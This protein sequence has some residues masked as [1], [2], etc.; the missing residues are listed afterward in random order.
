MIPGTQFTLNEVAPDK[1]EKQVAQTLTNKD[2][3]IIFTVTK[4]GTYKVTETKA[5]KGYV[6]GSTPYTAE[7]TVD[8]TKAFQKQTLDLSASADTETAVK[9]DLTVTGDAYAGS[10]ISNIRDTGT[11]TLTKENADRQSLNGVKFELYKKQKA[12]NLF[13]ALKELFTGK[14]YKYKEIASET[15]DEQADS[16]GTLT[17]GDLPWG[18][19]YIVETGQKGGYAL[20]GTKYE[21]TIDK[22]SG[23]D[24]QLLVSLG[25]IVNAY[26][27]VDIKKTDLNGVALYGGV[28]KL[29]G[30]F[31]DGSTE[32]Q[33]TTASEAETI[34]NKLITG[35]E[36]TLSEVSA[37]AGHIRTKETAAIRL[38]E[39]GTLISVK[40]GLMKSDS[41][42]II[43][44]NKPVTMTVQKYSPLGDRLK[45][46]VFA[47]TG[48]FAPDYSGKARMMSLSIQA[49]ADDS[50]ETLIVDDDHLDIL[51]G[52]LIVGNIY[53]L[54]E[55]TPPNGYVVGGKVEFK[56]LENGDIEMLSE[57]TEYT[58]DKNTGRIVMVDDATT[59]RL[60]KTDEAGNYLGGAVY[61]VEGK[62]ADGTDKKEFSP[63]ANG[64]LE[65]H[66]LFIEGEQY[67]LTE[68]KA[69]K[70][71]EA[72]NEPVIF[73]FL[74][75]NGAEIVSAPEGMA[76]LTSET[77]QETIE[78][79]TYTINIK[80]KKTVEQT[81][82]SGNNTDK[83]IPTAAGR[84]EAA[85]TGDTADIINW[86]ILGTVAGA[87]MV[88]ALVL[89][90]R[91]KG[92]Q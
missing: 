2:G 44:Q 47:V 11:V 58:L 12:G 76:S 50:V 67:T 40:G 37:P 3:E 35:E 54:Q 71:Y 59:L 31:L 72:L 8:N 56:V 68:T 57:S 81:Q 15:W 88:L 5:A 86:A 46:C 74:E 21:F 24:I 32:Y 34:V 77:K 65:I 25:K 39:D 63:T 73:N 33:W 53:T 29:E 18:S 13:E 55:Q 9:Y 17:I 16:G 82:N 84:V 19:Y 52:R 91:Q 64:V 20:D 78:K 26:T 92:K 61:T 4:K 7:F 51:N 79:T 49:A 30:D 27:S 70:G 36:Y 28:L 83:K 62:F 75:R 43:V 42:L 41:S 14:S 85:S 10:G 38:N 90:R 48:V 69:P 23:T 80:N 66:E 87:A 45:G 89:I 60:A 6:L 1:T 22:T